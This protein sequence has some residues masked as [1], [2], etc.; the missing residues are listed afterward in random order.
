MSKRHG[1][2]GQAMTEAINTALNLAKTLNAK[3][4]ISD[5]RLAEYE[6]KARLAEVKRL[7]AEP[8]VGPMTPEEFIDRLREHFVPYDPET[9]VDE[10]TAQL[11]QQIAEFR[12]RRS[13]R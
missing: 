10:C 1:W 8:S 13:K 9:F 4:L 2:A 6:A 3:G 12:E 11:E 7:D 5:E